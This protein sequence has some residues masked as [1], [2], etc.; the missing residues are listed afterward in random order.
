VEVGCVA[1]I[2]EEHTA[3]I[4][5]AEVTTTLLIS[6]LMMEAV[7]FSETSVTEPTSTQYQQPKAGSTSTMNHH[8]SL[9]A[10][11]ITFLNSSHCL[12]KSCI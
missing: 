7:C 11:K 8:E 3:S 2:S 1:N 6:A 9:E 5:R 12:S 4:M 10:V